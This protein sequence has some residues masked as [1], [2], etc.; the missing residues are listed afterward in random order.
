MAFLVSLQNKTCRG[1]WGAVSG[2][3]TIRRTDRIFASSSPPFANAAATQFFRSAAPGNSRAR[4]GLPRPRVARESLRSRHRLLQDHA[5]RL[6]YR[7]CGRRRHGVGRPPFASPRSTRSPLCK[8]RE[9]DFDFVHMA[10]EPVGMPDDVVK[11]VKSVAAGKDRHRQR[12][13]DGLRRLLRTQ[14]EGEDGDVRD[15]IDRKREPNS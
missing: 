2:C 3:R 5:R 1:A 9:T 13:D 10:V 15:P 14:P 11:V 6:R 12:D 8:A 7:R 4:A